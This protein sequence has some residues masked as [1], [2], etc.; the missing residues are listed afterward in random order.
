[1]SSPAKIFY[2]RSVAVSAPAASA[3]QIEHGIPFP[4]KAGRGYVYPFPDMQVGDSFAVACAGG[5]TYKLMNNLNACSRGYAKRTGGA[6]KFS[7]RR[8]DGGVRIW[9]VA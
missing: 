5:D 2:D 3:P 1:M 4:R 9:R 6:A 7:T 8:V